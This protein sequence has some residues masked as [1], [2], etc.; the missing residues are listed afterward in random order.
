[1][2]SDRVLGLILLA[3]ALTAG[4]LSV[5]IPAGLGTAT[6]S[7]A[8]FP[9]VLAGLLGVAGVWLIVAGR[10]R[11]TW[12]EVLDRRVL[13]VG[14]AL[15]AYYL[16]FA[17]VDFRVGTFLFMAAAMA[18]LG[19][20]RPAELLAVPL[21]TALGVFAVFRYGFGTLLPTWF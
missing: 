16:S 1:M 6:L 7:P 11:V 15:L 5:T 20:R 21:A 2:G 4:G 12:G 19:A 8:F 3:V 13:L 10:S 9:Q 18:A 14:A 17:Y